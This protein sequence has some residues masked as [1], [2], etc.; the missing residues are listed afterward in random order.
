MHDIIR[1][2]HVIMHLVHFHHRHAPRVV[3]HVV[4]HVVQPPPLPPMLPGPARRRRRSK[5]Y[6]CM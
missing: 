6:V 4:R 3:V 2:V 1:L 5:V